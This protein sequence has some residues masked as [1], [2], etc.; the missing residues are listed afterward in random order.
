MK[1]IISLIRRFFEW[2]WRRLVKGERV[3]L[4]AWMYWTNPKTLKEWEEQ[5]DRMEEYLSYQMWEEPQWLTRDGVDV[6]VMMDSDPMVEEGWYA[7][8]PIGD[9]GP[10]L[11]RLKDGEELEEGEEL[12]FFVEH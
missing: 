7:K 1:E 4:G 5:E 3:E 9:W 12:V 2:L 8:S 11:R 6:L 10:Y